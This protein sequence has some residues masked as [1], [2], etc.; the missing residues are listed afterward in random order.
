MLH[1]KTTVMDNFKTFF[2]PIV[3]ECC[4]LSHALL[5]TECLDDSR[6]LNEEDNTQENEHCQ[7][8]N[9]KYSDDSISTE[10]CEKRNF[11]THIGY[12]L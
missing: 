4:H 7:F 11:E 5:N 3:L 1:K 9:K 2:I 10:S 6:I 8:I 12:L